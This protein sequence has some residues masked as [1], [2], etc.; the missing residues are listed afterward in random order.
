MLVVATSGTGYILGTGNATVN[1]SG[2]CYTCAGTMMI[3]ASANSLNQFD[4]YS[5]LLTLVARDLSDVA[6]QLPPPRRFLLDGD[7]SRFI[8]E[9]LFIIKND[10]FSSR[11]D[12]GGIDFNG[13]FIGMALG[14]VLSNLPSIAG[15]R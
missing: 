14:R 15:G 9:L 13:F 2:L 11:I 1:L 6:V 4:E 12:G 5:R 7:D 3:A 8:F 10:R